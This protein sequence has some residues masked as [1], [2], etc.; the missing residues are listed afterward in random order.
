[1]RGIAVGI[2]VL[3]LAGLGLLPAPA[4]ARDP[5]PALRAQESAGEVATR[6]AAIAC[7][8]WQRWQQP[9]ITADGRLASASVWEGEA[10]G[11]ADG[12]APWRRVAQYWAD[13]G[14]AEREGGAVCRAALADPRD[15]GLACR[16]F[17]IDVPWSAAFVSWVLQRA[18]V[19]GFRP[20]AAHFEYVRAALREPEGSPY[21]FRDPRST[22]P[23]PGDL[24]CYVRTRQLRGMDGLA[25]LI[26]RGERGLAMHCDIVVSTGTPDD[27]R[28]WL[29]GGNLLQA[30]TLR[31]LPLNAA[32][33]FW[34]LP[35]RGSDDPACSPDTPAY[36]DFNRQDWAVL[37]QLRPQD[38]LA[39]LGAVAPPATVATPPDVAPEA[40]TPC[41]VECVLGS[42]IRRCREGEVPSPAEPPAQD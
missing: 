3:L 37:L 22:P 31:L 8:E 20:A 6:I 36:C 27:A 10:R 5:C 33:R 39:R 34:G 40:A 35:Q 29:V 19:P 15:P 25:A 30:V 42:G 4:Q 26:A 1:M 24:L 16:A 11:L 21:H 9:F 12:G 32:G 7:A 23:A 17:V 18:G 2:S 41:C 38:E 28:A 13:I 14:L